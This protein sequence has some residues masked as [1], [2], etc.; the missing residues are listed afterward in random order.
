V[1]FRFGHGRALHN[2]ALILQ[3]RGRAA[4]ALAL[5]RE[6]APNLADVYRQNVLEDGPRRAVSHAYWLLCTLLVDRKDHRS[7]AETAASYQS[8]EPNGYEEAHEA[9]IF[10]CRCIVL[11]GDDHDMAPAAKEALARSYADR[12]IAALETAVRYGFRDLN[13]LRTS[14]AYDPLRGRPDF[15]AIAKQVGELDQPVSAG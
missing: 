9:A 1:A 13:E 2:L 5:A 8:I 4:E 3:Q 14:H 12:A 11:C 7:A 6:A 15:A 10:L